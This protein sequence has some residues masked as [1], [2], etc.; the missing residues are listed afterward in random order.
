MWGEVGGKRMCFEDFNRCNPPRCTCVL[1]KPLSF[2]VFS[3][4]CEWSHSQFRITRHL[5]NLQAPHSHNSSSIPPRLWSQPSERKKANKVLR[6]LCP[7]EQSNT[8]GVLECNCESN[9]DT[10]KMENTQQWPEQVYLTLRTQQIPDPF[11]NTEGKN[12]I[13]HGRKSL[14]QED[15]E[16][17]SRKLRTNRHYSGMRSDSVSGRIEAP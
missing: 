3:D 13:H 9:F 7:F 15:A 17:E 1:I 14:E 16:T 12:Q 6:N 11:S 4:P 10:H 8:K 2:P 5:G